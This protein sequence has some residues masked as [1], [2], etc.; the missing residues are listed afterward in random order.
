MELL[1]KWYELQWFMKFWVNMSNIAALFCAHTAPLLGSHASALL[2]LQT[3]DK[4]RSGFINAAE[5]REALVNNNWSHF[6]EETCRILIGMFDG[7][8]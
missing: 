2:T 3:V 1:S 8:K 5:L 4:D 7:N 6:N